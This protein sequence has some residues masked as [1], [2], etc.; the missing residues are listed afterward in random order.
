MVTRTVLRSVP[1][2]MPTV[3]FRRAVAAHVI[4]RLR[5]HVHLPQQLFDAY[6]GLFALRAEVIQFLPELGTVGHGGV[7]FL[8]ETGHQVHG[9]MD[10]FFE[11]CQGVVFFHNFEP[12]LLYTFS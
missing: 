7:A 1:E 4:L 8:A 3:S 5:E 6:A 9:E 2:S 12:R 10:A 11:T